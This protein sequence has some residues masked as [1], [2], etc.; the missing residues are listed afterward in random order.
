MY[1]VILYLK[2]IANG[3]KKHENGVKTAVL[4]GEREKDSTIWKIKYDKNKTNT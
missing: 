2:M 1:I 4:K 3:N